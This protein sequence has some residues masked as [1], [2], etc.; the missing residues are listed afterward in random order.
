VNLRRRL[1][2]PINENLKWLQSVASPQFL[3]AW[4]S[5]ACGWSTTVAID[6]LPESTQ[7]KSDFASFSL[8]F[9]QE[10]GYIT[11]QEEFVTEPVTLPADRYPAVKKFF[12]EFAG[13][14]QQRAV[15]IKH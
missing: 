5:C 14:D 3:L 13:A 6:E 9:K 12:D 11:L 4:L 7:E 1:H 2:E 8:T 10:P 15:L